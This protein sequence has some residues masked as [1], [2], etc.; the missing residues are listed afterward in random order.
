MCAEDS[1]YNNL[2]VG[3]EISKLFEFIKAF[4]VHGRTQRAELAIDKYTLMFSHESFNRQSICTNVHTDTQP[5]AHHTTM[6]ISYARART[7]FCPSDATVRP[8]A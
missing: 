3:R 4:K 6:Q 1:K 2:N 7:G 8:F 5:C